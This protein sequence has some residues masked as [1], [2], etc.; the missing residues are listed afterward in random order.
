MKNLENDTRLRGSYREVMQHLLKYS[1]LTNSC[2]MEKKVT[3]K[4]CSSE[5]IYN[6]QENVSF[7]SGILFYSS[8]PKFPLL[9]FPAVLKNNNSLQ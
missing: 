2:K 1:F 9:H 7:N 3:K 5:I 4:I 8:D 6:F